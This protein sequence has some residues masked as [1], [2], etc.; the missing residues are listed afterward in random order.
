MFNGREAGTLEPICTKIEIGVADDSTFVK[1]EVA[2]PVDMI[3][4]AYCLTETSSQTD[5]VHESFLVRLQLACSPFQRQKCPGTSRI[6]A[7]RTRN[8]CSQLELAANQ[9]RSQ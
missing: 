9:A 2:S 5:V 6:E 4:A 1:T 8:P 7:N 3:D